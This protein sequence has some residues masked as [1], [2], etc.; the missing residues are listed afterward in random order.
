MRKNILC[1]TILSFVTICSFADSPITSTSF[2]SA[3][4]EIPQIYN[5][6]KEGVLTYEF[7]TFLS[8]PL[9]SADKK[10]ALINAL[11][12]SID[13]KNNMELY[14]KFLNAKYKSSNLQFQQITPDEHLC[15]GY[16]AIMDDYFHVRQPLNILKGALA[17]NPKSYTYN[18]IYSLVLAQMSLDV[19]TRSDSTFGWDLVD[20]RFIDTTMGGRCNVYTI[21]AKIEADKSLKQDF[22]TS[23][24][25][26]IFS[27]INIYKGRCSSDDLILIPSTSHLKDLTD[28]RVKLIKKGGVYKVPVQ[29]NEGVA[30]DFILDSGA[31][32]VL[33]SSDI[34]STLVKQG[35]IDKAD[36]LGYE[37]YKIADGSTVKQVSIILRKLQVGEIVVNNVKASVGTSLSPLLLGQ[38]FMQKFKQF[39]I[40]NENGL[41]LIDPKYARMED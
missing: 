3:Y 8:S 5:A 18:I 20:T 35:K 37:Y 21:L 16:L 41:L 40:D 15:I 38:S 6:E 23:A 25:R 2:Y 32:D 9:V 27:Y 36:I 31:S 26:N 10:V 13:G 1:L 22:R 29:I 14:V 34:F 30:V 11:G 33:I 28:T 7:A 17:R 24:R 12:W 4:N 39:T 19:G